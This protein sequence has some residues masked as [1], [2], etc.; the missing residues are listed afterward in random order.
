MIG[1]LMFKVKRL[2]RILFVVVFVLN[3]TTTYTYADNDECSEELLKNI[4]VAIIN[5]I[6][7]QEVCSVSNVNPAADIGENAEIVWRFF[8]DKLPSHQIAGI[9][10]NMAAESGIQPQ[11]L[12]GT[13]S[14]VVTPASSVPRGESQKAW[15]FVHWDPAHKMIDPVTS[16]G[17]DPNS[18]TVQ[19]DFLWKQLNG[20][21]S[22]P[23]KAAGNHLKS[24]TTVQEATESFAKKYERPDAAALS[25]S[26]KDRISSAEA[27]HLRFKDLIP[28]TTTSV[29]S[30]N[31]TTASSVD[32]ECGSTTPG[33]NS[34]GVIG[35]AQTELAKAPV[36]YDSN[37]FKYTDKN[38]EAWCADFVSWVHKEAGIP[39]SGGSSGGWRRAS[40]LDL[41]SMFKNS[42]KYKYFSVGA[43]SPQPGDIAFYIGSQTP[44]RSSTR[45]VNIV[46][47]V[48]GDTMTTIG[49]NESNKVKKSTRKI[50]SGSQG[51]VGFGR[52][53]K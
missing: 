20:E 7:N 33:I 6:G 45:H 30:G 32:A 12:Q 39:F 18:P 9:L 10:G 43:E 41:Q 38:E 13:K 46:I 21:T 19:L 47:E 37:V 31:D 27:A 48:N 28:T 51:L 23:E 3:I 52:V 22:S 15:G 1:T 49:G 4:S 35:V 44:D 16:K 5:C 29:G 24:T 53:I 2:V 50:A 36:E 8:S 14:G 42:E 17:G 26:L 11:R 34:S 40:V 25:N